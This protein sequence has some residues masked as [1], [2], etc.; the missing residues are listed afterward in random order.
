MPPPKKKAKKSAS[1]EKSAQKKLMYLVTFDDNNGGYETHTSKHAL[2]DSLAKAKVGG[3]NLMDANSPW[4]EDWK[5]EVEGLGR[6]DKDG[7]CG[8]D[9]NPNLGKS[10]GVLISNEDTDD[11]HKVVVSIQLLEVNPPPEKV[12][13]RSRSPIEE[14]VYSF[15]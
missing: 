8:F 10:G 9:Y 6:E 7:Y 3:L 15:M 4:G 2:Y 11:S 1:V 5:N 12:S 13:S 14:E